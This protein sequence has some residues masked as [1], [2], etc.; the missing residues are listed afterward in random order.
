MGAVRVVTD[1]TA[2]LPKELAASL[3]VHVVPLR[4]LF[5]N[6][7]YADGVDLTDEEF[8]RRLREAKVLPRTSQPSAG[9]F[10]EVYRRL[11]REGASVI[12][13][14]ISGKLSGTVASAEAARLMLPEA[15][16]TV[17]D[18]LSVSMGLGLLVLRAAQAAQDGRSH[19][20]IVQLVN[21]LSPRVRVM[22]VVDTLEYLQRGGRIGGA[23]ALVGSLLSL[24]PILGV[25]DGR[26]EAL[27]KVRT[28]AKAVERMLALMEEEVSAGARLHAAVLHGQAP[29]EAAALTERLK[30]RFQPVEVFSSDVGPVLATHA[31]PGVVGIAFYVEP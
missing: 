22:F 12:S 15:E 1:S 18:T 9:E 10:A 11:A 23:A 7:A 21:Q 26:V 28:K 19:G 29:A 31:G 8:Y 3:H 17:I 20:E 30:A 14:H 5:G 16:I 24:K 4:V 6:E 2:N 25:R 13:I 27:E